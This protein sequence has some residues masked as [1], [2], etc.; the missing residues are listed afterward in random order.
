MRFGKRFRAIWLAVHS[1][2]SQKDSAT[3]GLLQALNRLELSASS[4]SYIVE[5]ELSAMR[6]PGLGSGVHRQEGFQ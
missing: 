3:L 2:K 1:D 5:W 4:I 6:G